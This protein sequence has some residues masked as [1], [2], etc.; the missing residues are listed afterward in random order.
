[1]SGLM[2]PAGLLAAAPMKI[3][4]FNPKFHVT[5]EAFLIKAAFIQRFL[6]SATLLR[7]M[8]AVPE[9]AGGCKIVYFRESISKAILITPDLYLPHTWSIDNSAAIRK[10]DQFAVGCGVATL[11]VSLPYFADFHEILSQQAIYYC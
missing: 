1:M 5:V 9:T 3:F 4:K 8:A 7:T 6:Y 11:A 2:S 10:D